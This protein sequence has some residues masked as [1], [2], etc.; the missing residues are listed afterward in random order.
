LSCANNAKRATAFPEGLG[1]FQPAPMPQS[2]ADIPW[3]RHNIRYWW[4]WFTVSRCYA[5]GS[6]S[7]L[8]RAAPASAPSQPARKTAVRD[9]SIRG[10]VKQQ[11]SATALCSKEKITKLAGAARCR[12]SYTPIRR[13]RP[14]QRTARAQRATSGVTTLP[15]NRLPRKRDPQTAS[16]CG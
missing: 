7:S 9:I 8:V 1:V 14:A 10:G 5:S 13:R 4:Q 15:L 2:V 16:S 3:A 11:P 6:P 12:I